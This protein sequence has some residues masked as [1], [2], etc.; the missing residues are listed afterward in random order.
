MQEPLGIVGLMQFINTLGLPVAL[1]INF[2]YS[3][4]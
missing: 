3:R 4:F 1:Y 2:C